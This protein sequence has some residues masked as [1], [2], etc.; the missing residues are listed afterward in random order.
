MADPTANET[1]PVHDPSP[2]GVPFLAPHLVCD[3]AAAAIDFYAKAFGAQEMMR[4]PGPDGRLVHAS[5]MI[6]GAMV[7]LVDEMPE[8]GMRGP[9]LLGGTPVTLHLAVPDADAVVARAVQAGATVVMPVAD[10]FWGDRYGVIADPFGHHWSV[11]TPG[12]DAPRTTEAL[13]EAMRQGAP[14]QA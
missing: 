3:G 11:A 7:M 13:Q 4:L 5:V 12:K 14:E 8:H 10:Q 9:K 1:P 6:N 2:P